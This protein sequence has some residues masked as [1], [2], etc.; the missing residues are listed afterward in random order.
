MVPALWTLERAALPIEPPVKFV[1]VETEPVPEPAPGRA[2]I[3]PEVRPQEV[4]EPA[5]AASIARQEEAVP[6]VAEKLIPVSPAPDLAASDGGVDTRW[7]VAAVC[8]IWLGGA[9]FVFGRWGAAALRFR[10]LWRQAVPAGDSGLVDQFRQIAGELGLPRTPQLMTHRRIAVP[11][12]GGLLRARVLLPN[13]CARW[14]EED[15]R[16][17][18]LHELVHVKR[19]DALFHLLSS[20]VKALHWMNPLAWV[21]VRS[22]RASAE[23]AT[24]DRVLEDGSANPSYARLLVDFASRQ[25]A[26]SSPSTP[27]VASSMAQ[28]D[29]VESRVRRILDSGQRR[30]RPGGIVVMLI[31]GGFA[32]L[33]GLVGGIVFADDRSAAAAAVDE[34]IKADAKSQADLRKRLDE[35]TVESVSFSE[36]TMAEAV[37]FCIRKSVEAD[38]AG[39]GLNMIMIGA[40]GVPDGL[41]D[42]PAPRL[43]LQLRNIPLSE[44]LRYMGLLS[45]MKLDVE[46]HSIV[47]RPRSMEGGELYSKVFPLSA[48]L[49]GKAMEGIEVGGA[50]GDDDPFATADDLVDVAYEPTAR[51]WLSTAGVQFPDGS[52]A[53]YEP[54]S[55]KLIVRNT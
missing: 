10:R 13:D 3:P 29:T 27:A 51:D 31:V 12:A 9:L 23:C 19:R 36:A 47:F 11:M 24:D 5:V 17:V 14:P 42:E 28:P 37:Q 21:V 46:P 6:V 15:R 2:P 48:A 4:V 8:G 22:V 25:M 39:D 16:M 55:G 20:L 32:G 33:L 49:I 50:W 38:P 1:L 53:L 35:I 44:L 45:G 30:A 40:P 41:G 52:S 54:L 7:I 18:V 34:A 26:S 43:N